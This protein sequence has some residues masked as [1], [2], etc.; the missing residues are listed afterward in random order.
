MATER[1]QFIK[2]IASGFDEERK[3]LMPKNSWL[4][5]L[6]TG[7]ETTFRQLRYYVKGFVTRSNNFRT[8]FYVEI[9]TLDDLFADIQECSHFAVN[10]LVYEVGE[11]DPFPPSGDRLSW[12]IYGAF[13]RDTYAPVI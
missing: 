6:G 7:R 3:I 12:M 10:G 4:A 8:G 11:G 5:L 2:E 9:A 13:V 1:E